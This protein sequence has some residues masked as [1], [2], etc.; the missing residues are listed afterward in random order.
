LR[1]DVDI[2]HRGR[3]I[4][5]RAEDFRDIL[6]RGDPAY[7]LYEMGYPAIMPSAVYL[8]Q[9]IGEAQHHSS[10]TIEELFDRIGC[11]A[12]ETPDFDPTGLQADLV[13]ELWQLRKRA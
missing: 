13:V 2:T 10:R 1:L 8:Y 9:T 12:S 11:T 6:N 7:A 4:R 3:R 5:Q